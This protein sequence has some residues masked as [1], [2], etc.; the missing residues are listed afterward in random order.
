MRAGSRHNR[1]VPRRLALFLSSIAALWAGLI[2]VAPVALRSEAPAPAVGAATVYAASARICHQQHERSFAMAGTPLPVCARCAGLYLSGAVGALLAWV[3][4]RRRTG[5]RDRLVLIACAIPTALT[6]GLEVAGV[7]GLSNEARAIAALP[8]G[9]AAGWTFVRALRD[10][11]RGTGR[12]TH[13]EPHP[14]ALS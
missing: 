12:L 11:A 2:L 7:T 14:R 1:G 6:W 8:L 3:P 9:G 4:R 13:A 5:A 10:E